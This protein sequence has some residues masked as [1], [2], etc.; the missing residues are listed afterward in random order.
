MTSRGIENTYLAFPFFFTSKY[1][2]HTFILTREEKG[3]VQQLVDLP[4]RQIL[5]CCEG[6]KQCKQIGQKIYEKFRDENPQNGCAGKEAVQK[7]WNAIP[8]YCPDGLERKLCIETA[9]NGI[10]DNTWRWV[11]KSRL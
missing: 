1:Q 8:S 6:Q 11:E 7:I 5:D 4:L 3:F 10:G 9:W 2:L